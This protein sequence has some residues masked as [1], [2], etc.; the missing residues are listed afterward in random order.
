MIIEIPD[1]VMSSDL[2]LSQKLVIGVFLTNPMMSKTELAKQLG[3]SRRL[4]HKS[5][6]EAKSKCE[7]VCTQCAPVFSQCAPACTRSSSSSNNR[8]TPL[9]D[10]LNLPSIP[11]QVSVLEVEPPT[12]EEVREYAMSIDRV[13]LADEFFATSSA[14][15]W[16]TG[17][18]EPIQ[19]WRKW[20]RG[21]AGKKPKTNTAATR[22]LS[23][24]TPEQARMQ[25]Y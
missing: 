5:L 3:I 1:D 2:T 24:L 18:G 12:Q 15:G 21:W 17:R 7:L 23:V 16:K 6:S 25:P 8:E 19:N 13:D 11:M 10:G 9:P 4:V 22:R 20:F 14:D